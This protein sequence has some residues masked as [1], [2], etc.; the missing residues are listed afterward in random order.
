MLK[1]H[2]SSAIVAVGDLDRA[3]A[4]YRRHGF[5]ERDPLHVPDGGPPIWPNTE[6]RDDSPMIMPIGPPRRKPA[7]AAGS[8]WLSR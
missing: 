6:I 5:V 2:D 1:D 4:F 3:R 7:K 8:A